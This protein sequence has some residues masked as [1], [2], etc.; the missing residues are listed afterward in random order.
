MPTPRERYDLEVAPGRWPRP[1]G[2]GCPKDIRAE[3]AQ[4]D[5]VS[6]IHD[7]S[8]RTGSGRHDGQARTVPATAPR[9][10]RN[11]PS[12]A[13]SST[14]MRHREECGMAIAMAVRV[15]PKRGAAAPGKP[16]GHDRLLLPTG[17]MA[18]RSVPALPAGAGLGSACGRARPIALHERRVHMVD[19]RRQDSSVRGRASAGLR[20]APLRNG[21]PGHRAGSG[22]EQSPRRCGRQRAHS[23]VAGGGD[24]R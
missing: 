9:G 22:A 11:S 15:R 1:T 10:R 12:E 14:G 2:T 21:R 8:S 3:M 6:A 4:R 20:A 5:G 24:I 23:T 17:G 7:P 13:A 18:S 19:V 16:S